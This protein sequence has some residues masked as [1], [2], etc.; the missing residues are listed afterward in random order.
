M[1]KEP[2]RILATFVPNCTPV[3]TETKLPIDVVKDIAKGEK[4]KSPAP[5]P[6]VRAFAERAIP[7]RIASH[8]LISPD[9]SK[10]TISGFSKISFIEVVFD[11]TCCIFLVKD[12]RGIA[13]KIILSPIIKSRN[14]PTIIGND[15][16]RILFN[17]LPKNIP[18]MLN[19]KE[20]TAIIVLEKR[21]IRIFRIP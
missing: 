18:D 11:D 4:P 14:A 20:I 13:S 6:F 19:K 7:K 3:H 12:L 8:K 5:S 1:V 9:L 2:I 10:S 17:H 16:G 15:P 21:L